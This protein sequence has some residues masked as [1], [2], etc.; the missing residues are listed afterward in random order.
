MTVTMIVMMSAVF[1]PGM[2]VGTVLRN[3]TVYKGNPNTTVT[4]NLTEPYSGRSV[5]NLTIIPLSPEQKVTVL[6]S[7]LSFHC[8]I[9]WT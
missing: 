4:Y 7:A 9:Q 6:D 8:A 5:N 2:V 3:I 1:L